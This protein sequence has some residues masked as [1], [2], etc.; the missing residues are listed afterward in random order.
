MIGGGRG[1]IWQFNDL[2]E[3]IHM[4]SIIMRQMAIDTI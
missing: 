3:D 4:S 2:E 1:A